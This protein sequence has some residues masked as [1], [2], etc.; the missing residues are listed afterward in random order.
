MPNGKVHKLVGAGAGAGVGYLCARSEEPAD[1]L[2]E[3][4][5]AVLG[6][7]WGGQL[8]DIL[9]PATS[10]NHRSHGHAVLPNSGIL[11]WYIQ[12]AP[13]WQ[14]DLRA[15]AREFG[16]RVEESEAWLTRLFWALAEIMTRMLS[17][18]VAGLPAGHTS[19]LLLDLTTPMRLPVF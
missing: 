14:E 4:V 18:A 10:P 19:H 7:Y 6:G 13:R 2:I 5:G 16:Q 15:R 11:A 8:P 17:G 12:N 9:D 1:R 3:T